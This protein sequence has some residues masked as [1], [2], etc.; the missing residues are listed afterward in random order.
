M[1]DSKQ[2]QSGRGKK[3]DEIDGTN[4]GYEGR[5]RENADSLAFADAWNKRGC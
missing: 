3:V 4:A 5:D 1:A 2:L